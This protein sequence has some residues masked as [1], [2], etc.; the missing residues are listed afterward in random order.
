[1]MFRLRGF[2]LN[3]L[4][5]AVLASASACGCG[6]TVERKQKK[7]MTLLRLHLETSSDKVPYTSNVSVLRASPIQMVIHNQSFLDERSI[8][9]AALVD[10]G[11]GFAIQLQFDQRGR[12]HLETITQAARGQRIAIFSEFG[13]MRWL[14]AVKIVQTVTDGI[15]TFTPDAS[16]EE[17]ERIVRGLNNFK[18]RQNKTEHF[19]EKS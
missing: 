1:M 16:R 6:T 19:P 11:H 12:F 17:A 10:L 15:L 9:E 5:V 8:I 18:R 2:N 14:A 4:L 7:E 3:L 13:E